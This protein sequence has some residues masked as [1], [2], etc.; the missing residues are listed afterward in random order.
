MPFLASKIVL[1]KQSALLL[2][3]F[4][5]KFKICYNKT[6]LVEL[7]KTNDCCLCILKLKFTRLRF[8]EYVLFFCVKNEPLLLTTKTNTSII[9]D[10]WF[11]SPI[12]WVHYGFLHAGRMS[13]SLVVDPFFHLQKMVAHLASSEATDNLSSEVRQVP[14]STFMRTS[15][16]V[17]KDDFM[18]FFSYYLFM[19]RVSMNKFN[20]FGNSLDQSNP[21]RGLV[22]YRN[23]PPCSRDGSINFSSLAN[24]ISEIIPI[25]SFIMLFP[26]ILHA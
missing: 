18:G 10:R 2:L 5:I 15:V 9:G 4:K 22:L 14:L 24:N 19:V 20:C 17:E 13:F 16:T 7:D 11:R 25:R 23:I 6:D 21:T 26:M 3:D 1:S 12:C 8:Y